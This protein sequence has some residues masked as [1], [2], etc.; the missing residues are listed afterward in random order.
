MTFCRLAR[1]QM[2]GRS[3]LDKHRRVKSMSGGLAE[4]EYSSLATR[5]TIV[6]GERARVLRL[7]RGRGGHRQGALLNEPAPTSIAVAAQTHG[8]PPS[9]TSS[10]SGGLE[11]SHDLELAGRYE[12]RR[13]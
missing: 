3:R 11:A 4:L 13:S 9:G 12:D 1:R 2:P 10:G 8:P 7:A 5:G 6:D